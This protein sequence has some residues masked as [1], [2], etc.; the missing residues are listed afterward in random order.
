MKKIFILAFLSLILISCTI[1]D[2]FFKQQALV[3]VNNENESIELHGYFDGG[4]KG[5]LIELGLLYQFSDDELVL[6]IFNLDI[7]VYKLDKHADHIMHEL[8]DIEAY[9]N[10]NLYVRTYIKVLVEGETHILYSEQTK[11]NLFESKKNDQDEFAA[12]II[13]KVLGRA[14]INLIELEIDYRDYTVLKEPEYL[15]VEVKFD[16]KTV[17]LIF[18]LID[19]KYEFSDALLLKVNGNNI[20]IK[21]KVLEGNILTVIYDDP[22]WSGIY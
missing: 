10:V 15:I 3:L 8:N 7:N 13:E 14:Q 18:K 22:N 1:Q 16:Y 12:K 2:Q 5:E 20:N 21:S 11:F 6:S 9:Y 4:Y 19:F 17:T